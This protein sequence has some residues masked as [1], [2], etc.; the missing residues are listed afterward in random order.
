MKGMDTMTV[1]SAARCP[2]VA[3]GAGMSR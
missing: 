2:G 3:P 1:D